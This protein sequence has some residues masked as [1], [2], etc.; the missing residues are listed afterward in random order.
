MLT[1]TGNVGC[2]DA[3]EMGFIKRLFVVEERIQLASLVLA[4]AQ[5][6]KIGWGARRFVYIKLAGM[7]KAKIALL[8]REREKLLMELE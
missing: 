2:R 8:E 1:T 7:C 3:Q 5:I 4:N 6:R